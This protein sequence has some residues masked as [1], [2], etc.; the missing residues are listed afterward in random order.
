[1]AVAVTARDAPVLI[2]NSE[3]G[4]LVLTDL[5]RRNYS[6]LFRVMVTGSALCA[7]AFDVPATFAVGYDVMCFGSCCHSK[8]LLEIDVQIVQSTELYVNSLKFGCQ[9]FMFS[10]ANIIPR[11][12]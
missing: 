1:M 11:K 4:A 10:I 8:S 3:L 9:D 7:A 12:M 2:V 5:P 6:F